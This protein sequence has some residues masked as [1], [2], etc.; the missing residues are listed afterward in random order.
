MVARRTTVPLWL[1]VV[2]LLALSVGDSSTQSGRRRNRNEKCPRVR[3]MRNFGLNAMMGPWYVLQYF[4][5]TEMFPEYGCM[6][7]SLFTSD[8]FVTMNFTYVFLDDPLATFQQGNITWIVPNYAQPA[9]WVH[10]ESSFEEV[11]NTYVIDTDYRSWALLMHCAEK[12]NSQKYL[13]ALMLSR[14]PTLGQNV[15][16][17]LREKLPRY[18][19]DVESMFRIP[20]DNCTHP[21]ADP[22]AYYAY[23]TS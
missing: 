13:S 22:H 11:Y 2:L 4:A 18:D 19:I 14:E 5:S 8:G 16:N 3:A 17:F 15:I 12:T 7:G 9:H 6:R 23:S 20:Q 1:V 21:V 10:A